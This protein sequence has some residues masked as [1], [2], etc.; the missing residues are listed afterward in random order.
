[1][2]LTSHVRVPLPVRVRWDEV[3]KHMMDDV[4]LTLYHPGTYIDMD[5]A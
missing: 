5:Y 4:G 1:M 3:D 2:A